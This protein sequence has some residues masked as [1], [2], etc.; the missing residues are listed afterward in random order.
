M[1]NL[2]SRNPI[3]V[4]FLICFIGSI[5]LLGW[6]MQPFLAIIIL[7]AVVSSLF[8]PLYHALIRRF[9]IRPWMASLTTCTLIF[10]ILFVPIV[11]FVSSLAQQAYGV[12]QMAR[13]AV[14]SEQ[15]TMVL[16]DTQVLEKA[17]AYL[18]RFNFELTGDEIKSAATEI[19]RYIAGFLYDQSK[20]I[21]SNTLNFVVNFILVLMVCFFLL[22]DGERLSAFVVDLSPLPAQQESMLIAKF[23]EMSGVILLVNGIGGAIQGI[24]GGLLFWS[25]GF[26]SA[27]LWGVIMGLL[28]FLPILGIGLVFLPAAL[29]LFLKGNVS[30]AIILIIVYGVLSGGTEYLLKPRLV[31]QRMKMHPLLVFFAVIGGLKLFGIL[32]IIYGPLIV[33]AF[34]T[35][36]EIYR[37]NYQKFV[38]NDRGSDICELPR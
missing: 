5:V 29:F 8:Y 28:A 10:F 27:F 17:N 35:L 14:I 2:I 24:V 18:V 16:N 33:T 7:G 11:F 13:T 30:G 36:A 15:I 20:V 19:I 37:A 9:K 6:V 32:G 26:Q 31:G 25:M 34:L 12:Y 3:L 22:I 23:K 21:A 4:F 38:E 1:G